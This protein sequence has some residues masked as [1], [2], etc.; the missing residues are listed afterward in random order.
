MP[1]VMDAI[2]G[3][4]AARGDGIQPKAL[5][6]QLRHI[7]SYSAKVAD[8]KTFDLFCFDADSSHYVL[9]MSL[10]A[11]PMREKRLKSKF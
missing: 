5:I 10:E 3:D 6:M 2:R 8:S 7:K 1:N 11:D 9:T 4:S